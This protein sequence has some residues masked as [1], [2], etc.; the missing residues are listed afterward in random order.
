MPLHIYNKALNI[1]SRKYFLK[2]L[3]TLPSGSCGAFSL[4]KK[5]N[6]LV[7]NINRQTS[8]SRLGCHATTHLAVL[9]QFCYTT[10]T[11]NWT[12]FIHTQWV[13]PISKNFKIETVRL[14][15][16]LGFF[17]P[18]LLRNKNTHIRSN[19]YSEE[20]W[21]TVKLSVKSSIHVLTLLEEFCHLAIFLLSLSVNK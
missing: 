8:H 9:Y 3:L 6:I 20:Q 14:L 13:F 16:P 2:N 1:P 18:T 21:G 7:C 15:P 10:V 19:D 11:L 4:W 12:F 17:L 5:Q